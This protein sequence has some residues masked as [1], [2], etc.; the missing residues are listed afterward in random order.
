M[1]IKR[2]PDAAAFLEHAQP[3]LTQREAENNLIL[4]VSAELVHNPHQWS[5]E[6]PY[7]ATIEQN[8]TIIGA[9]MRT[10]PHNLQLTAIDGPESAAALKALVDDVVAVYPALPVASG[11]K[12]TIRMFAERW[13]AVT[14]QSFTLTMALRIYQIT[15]VRPPANVP[16]SLRRAT[17]ADRELVFS[18]LKGFQHDAHQDEVND[19][20]VRR[21][22]ERWLTS[23]GRGL[24]I[25]ENGQPVSMAGVS[26]PTP[27]GIRVGA[28][29]TPPSFRGRGYASACVAALSQLQLDIG[30]TFCYLFTDLSNP[31]SNKIYQHIGYEPVV[32]IDDYLF[33]SL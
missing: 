29:Y 9:A 23:P 22:V 12:V 3:F 33:A 7:L 4:G 30:R 25:W 10:P 13:Q 27:H 17:D 19:D 18:W 2:Y 28:V 15:R 20:N 24:Y 1:K 5:Q 21:A 31:T 11:P 14:G 6:P 16:G 26:G 32:D 8:D